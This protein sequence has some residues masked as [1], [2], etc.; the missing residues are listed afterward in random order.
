MIGGLTCGRFRSINKYR[1][2][3]PLRDRARKLHEGIL[4]IRF[5]MPYNIWC[6]GCNNHIG[7]SVRFNAQKSK[8]GMYYTT[9]IHKFRMKCHLCD[10]HFEMQTDPKN[11]DYVILSGAR[12]QELRWDPKD[13][14]QVVPEE[15]EV[16]KKLATDSIHTIDNE[17]VVPEEREVSKKLATD[18]MFKLEHEV[19]DKAKAK[20]VAP[21]IQE[22]EVFQKRWKDDYSHN[23]A[24]RQTFRTKKKELKVISDSDRSLLKKSSLPLSMKLFPESKDDSK[25][26]QLIKLESTQS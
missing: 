6:D 8:T 19:E 4:I 23:R 21:V 22:L 17:Q 2:S 11:F 14:E 9:P 3:H 5:E 1:G 13:N 7:M 26:A 16:S 10:N 15:R 20:S 25:L 18:S 24:I 12:R